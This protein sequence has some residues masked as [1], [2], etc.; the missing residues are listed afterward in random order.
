MKGHQ[1]GGIKGGVQIAFADG[2]RCGSR[3]TA[4]SRRGAFT[5]TFGFHLM[6]QTLELSTCCT[7]NGS[8]PAF[9]CW[10]Q[11]PVMIF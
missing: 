5:V 1:A 9:A 3:G 11:H 7:E 6:A 10:R 4:R 2:D 8:L